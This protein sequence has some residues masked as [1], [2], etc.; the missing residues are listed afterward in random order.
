MV[1]AMERNLAGNRFVIHLENSTKGFAAHTSLSHAC[2]LRSERTSPPPS[3]PLTRFVSV[4]RIGLA[5]VSVSAQSNL[6]GHP[7]SAQEPFFKHVVKL[8]QS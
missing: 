7:Y 1:M 3:A 8:L 6:Y 4:R 2:A 5:A